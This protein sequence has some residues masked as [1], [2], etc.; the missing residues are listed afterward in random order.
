MEKYLILGGDK[1]ARG[2]VDTLLSLKK[3]V[4]V[5]DPDF[6]DDEIK[7]ENLKVYNK[8]IT[9]FKEDRNIFCGVT[10]V[11][12][13]VGKRIV[14]DVD[15]KTSLLLGNRRVIEDIDAKTI[16]KVMQVREIFERFYPNHTVRIIA[17]MIAKENEKLFIDAGVDEIIP[18]DMLIEKIMVQMVFNEG[19]V[20]NLILTLLTRNDKAYLTT[21]TVSKDSEYKDFIGKTYDGLLLPLLD[22]GMQLIA[23]EKTSNKD[24][25]ERTSIHIM[26]RIIIN[27]VESSEKNYSLRDNDRLIVLKEK[28]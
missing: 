16:I 12:I 28:G 27:P 23:I 8:E 10:T 3:E 2:I 19:I 26:D 21:V 24:S 14:N 18:T 22:K 1:T 17:E 15:E 5:V 6:K 11:I 20:S 9:D 4:I 25:N 13:L 7:S